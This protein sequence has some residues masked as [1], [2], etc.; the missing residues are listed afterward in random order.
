M[1]QVG[2]H[3]SVC[4]YVIL[5]TYVQPDLTKANRTK[6]EISGFKQSF[7]AC[8]YESTGRAIAVTLVSRWSRRC[9]NVTVFGLSV[10]KSIPLEYVNA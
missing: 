3:V 7:L 4:Q 1:L 9:S 6:A 10:C 8:L 2:F 5:V